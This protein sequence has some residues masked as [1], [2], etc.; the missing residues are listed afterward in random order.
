MATTAGLSVSADE[1]ASINLLLDIALQISVEL[2][3]RQMTLA[4]VLALGAGSVV[5]LPKPTTDALDVYVND[6]LVARGE[7]VM[8]G[9]RYGIRI[10]EVLSAGER[11]AAPAVG[12][13]R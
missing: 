8:V 2:G 12:D 13:G 7:A 11:V 5:E 4:E 10:S 3:R 1:G 6:R 9:E